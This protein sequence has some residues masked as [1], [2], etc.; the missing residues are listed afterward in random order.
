[1]KLSSL[2]S[3]CFI[4]VIFLGFLFFFL[5]YNSS[6]KKSITSD[7][8]V[9]IPG[10]YMIWK[11][12]D[13]RVNLEHPPLVK[14]F[15][16]LPLLPLDF[17]TPGYDTDWKHGNEWNFGGYFMFYYNYADMISAL[18]RFMILLLSF[19]LGLGVYFQ[20][21]RLLAPGK[22][23]SPY[24]GLLSAALYF[25]EP[26]IMAHSALVTYD[27]AFAFASFFAGLLYWSLHIHGFTLKKLVFFIIVMSLATLVK[28]VGVFLWMLIFLHLFCS[29]ILSKRKWR[30]DIPFIKKR[31]IRLKKHKFVAGV[32]LL[33]IC[34]L[35]S[36]IFLWGV[37]GFRYEISPGL[38]TPPGDQAEKFLS[39]EEVESRPVRS[40][41]VFLRDK[42]IIPQGYVSVLGHAYMEKERVAFMLG[43][44]SL[45]GGFYSY[46]LVTTLLKTPLPHLAILLLTIIALIVCIM[47]RLLKR[48]N[49]IRSRFVLYRSFIPL[50]LGAGFFVIMSLSR[51]NLGHRIILMVIP[52]MCLLSGN[53]FELYI[54]RMR[55]GAIP[56]R[57]AVIILLLSVPISKYPHYISYMNSFVPDQKKAFK[58]LADSNVDW[59]QDAR[60]LGE[61]LKEKRIH[62]VNLAFFGT[63]D[64]YYYGVNEWIDIG[65]YMILIPRCRKG[66]PDPTLYTAVSFN[67]LGYVSDTYPAVLQTGE[68]ELIGGSIL[69]FPP[70]L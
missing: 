60:F 53:L 26:S 45:E 24:A 11:T 70:V 29:A 16:T 41:L 43:K 32:I 21:S 28:I 48:E 47:Q 4:A 36:W 25:T 62:K 12:G 10:G 40:I 14:L 13:Y 27:L 44:A 52:F 67:M 49:K 54:P 2:N 23:V 37:Y 57:V 30:L 56:V 15:A 18:T 46:F 35:V 69:L 7:E 61:A 33:L 39:V 64:P 17:H 5:V 59:G 50:Y 3:R 42:S 31:F 8:V 9:H 20:G 22:R 55:R 38:E 66:P 6:T 58:Y 65:S 63:A 19:I 34:G 68:P 51:V 1:M